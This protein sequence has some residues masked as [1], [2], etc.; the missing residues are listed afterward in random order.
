MSE[1]IQTNFKSIKITVLQSYG[2]GIEIDLYLQMKSGRVLKI[3]H[4][5]D[6][7][8]DLYE[9]Y[10]QKGVDE[11]FLTEDDYNFFV[12]TVRDRLSAL[13]ADEQTPEEK[14]VKALSS[15]HDL[16]K[17]IL[18]Q[19]GLD[20]ERGPILKSLTNGT[21]KAISRTNIFQ[22]YKIF[23]QMCS[24]QYL[25]AMMTGYI[26]S[27]MIDQTDWTNDENKHKVVM[28]ALLCDVLLEQEDFKIMKHSL[29]K[30][31]LPD[32]II[33]HPL[34]TSQMLAKDSKFIPSETLTV[35]LQHHERPNGS[36]YPKSLQYQYIKPL[37][38]FYIVANYFTEKVFTE[39][40]T[41]ENK[42]QKTL[43]VLGH[44]KEKFY[45]GPFR[46]AQEALEKVFSSL[47]V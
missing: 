9:K 12:K 16:F 43:E 11:L 27:M 45:S 7:A 46:K 29:T 22:K 3:G 32:R 15:G 26:T 31:D 5:G 10:T 1:Q 41:E 36:G 40:Y 18:A 2:E 24:E 4:K 39:D 23:K 35:V 14:E 38:A 47:V 37:S 44:V 28:A 25:H 42:N 6:E 21:I 13:V 19:G 17:S 20:E 8:R 30:K 33:Q 34:T